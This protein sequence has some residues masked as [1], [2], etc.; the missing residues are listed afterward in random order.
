MWTSLKNLSPILQMGL[1]VLAV[2]VTASAAVFAL[3]R[4]KPQKDF[5]ELSAR[6]R[7]WW[8]MAAVF[9]AAILVSNRISLI[10]FA[11]LSFWAMKEY[12]TLLR[13]RPADHHALVLTFLAVPI[14][15]LW[16]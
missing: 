5:A 12:V 16:I 11:L 14:Q 1:L 6:V 3:Q 10:F 4:T 8:I 13:T 9:F 15:Y 2:L 7:A